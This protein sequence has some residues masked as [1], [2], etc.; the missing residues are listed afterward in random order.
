MKSTLLCLLLMMAPG[1]YA[2]SNLWENPS[3]VDEGKEPPRADFV[4]YETEKQVVENVK[5]N[6]PYVKS[7]NGMYKFHFSQN[8]SQRPIRFYEEDLDDSRWK[9]IRVPGNW[10]LQGFGI[11]VYTNNKYIFSR[12]P[13][14]VRTSR[15]PCTSASSGKL[16]EAKAS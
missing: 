3:V 13:P 14:L 9:T 15:S 5:W 12:N 2:Q 1:T 8:V 4:P 6:S 7:L 11:P 16:T 10:E